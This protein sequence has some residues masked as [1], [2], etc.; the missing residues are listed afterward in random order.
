[1]RLRGGCLQRG[2]KGSRLR[3]PLR[4]LPGRIL[5][6]GI[7]T[8]GVSHVGLSRL[9]G[10]L[11]RV[12]QQFAGLCQ[13]R[14][15]FRLERSLPFLDIGQQHLGNGVGGLLQGSFC[16]LQPLQV[17]TQVLDEFLQ[18]VQ[19]LVGL[20]R[21]LGQPGFP[22]L[23]DPLLGILPGLVGRL[24]HRLQLLLQVFEILLG[25]L[26]RLGQSWQVGRSLLRVG[27]LLQLRLQRLQ[28]L[29]RLG[30]HLPGQILQF[31]H[32]R[33]RQQIELRGGLGQLLQ[34]FRDL[35]AGLHVLGLLLGGLRQ[36]LPN[37]GQLLRGRRVQ[38]QRLRLGLG[39]VLASRGCLLGRLLVGL[40]LRLLQLL[41]QLLLPLFQRLQLL[42]DPALLLH[43]LVELLLQCLLLLLECVELPVGGL[44]RILNAN[45]KLGTRPALL[46]AIV[47]LQPKA[48]RVTRLQVPRRQIERMQEL[49]GLRRLRIPHDRPA[50]KP[51]L[52]GLLQRQH[53]LRQPEVVVH[54][55]RH[56]DLHRVRQQQLL[57]GSVNHNLRRRVGNPDV[58][59][60]LHR[61]AAVPQLVLQ[62]HPIKPGPHQGESPPPLV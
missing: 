3:L 15:G 7:V 17:G 38:W 51:G 30:L 58:A 41:G 43:Q 11:A 47:H 1:M 52:P 21:F 28:G 27:P 16:L 25:H 40:L 54:R 49:I 29:G 19:V 14:I 42:F 50:F 31:L 37:F 56:R 10:Q 4:I 23:I 13:L 59:P 48:D 33:L 45:H 44:R 62:S 39:S 9:L 26:R 20:P 8:S 36:F 22:Q 5:P 53:H 60:L 55:D 34:L 35:L 57:A 18:P 6:G 46:F 61:G 24:G 2:L 12:G 32:N